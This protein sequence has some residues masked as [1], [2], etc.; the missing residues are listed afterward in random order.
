MSETG[1]T[2]DVNK[3]GKSTEAVNTGSPRS[4]MG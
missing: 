3:G 2:R 1:S 4:F